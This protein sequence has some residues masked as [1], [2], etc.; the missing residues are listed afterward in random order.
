MFTS[1]VNLC[2]QHGA[3]LI[4]GKSAARTGRVVHC[5]RVGWILADGPGGCDAGHDISRIDSFVQS[6]EK[7]ISDILSLLFNKTLQKTSH[8]EIVALRGLGSGAF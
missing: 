5:S 2:A 8:Y 7:S 1:D 3:L 4:L 6:M